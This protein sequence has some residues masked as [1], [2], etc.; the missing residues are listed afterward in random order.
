MAQ[1]SKGYPG[2]PNLT[3]VHVWNSSGTIESLA[4]LDCLEALDKNLTGLDCL[5]YSAGLD[6]FET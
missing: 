5:D 3:Y 4:G 1:I 6:C 2:R